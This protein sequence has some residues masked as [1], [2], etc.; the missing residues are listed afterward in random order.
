MGGDLPLSGGRAHLGVRDG[1]AVGLDVDG[2][3]HIAVQR[4]VAVEEP[5]VHRR[6]A[7]LGPDLKQAAG[8][9]GR[10]EQAAWPFQHGDV[11]L[12]A[13]HDEGGRYLPAPSGEFGVQAQTAAG[14]GQDAQ[15][16]VAQ[17]QHRG[18]IG[19]D[20]GLMLRGRRA[21]IDTRSAAM[22]EARG[23]TGGGTGLPLENQTTPQARHR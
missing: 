17:G 13:A 20:I 1:R 22:A 2:S 14:L 11:A 15:Q 9:G 4:I 6:V 19:L 5:P 7:V 12:A 18:E 10:G 8:D 16:L 3:G 21:L 23:E